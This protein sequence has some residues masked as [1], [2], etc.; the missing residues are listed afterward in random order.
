MKDTVVNSWDD[1]RE[2][3]HHINV[4]N[5]NVFFMDWTTSRGFLTIFQKKKVL[6]SVIK[7]I[8]MERRE[9]KRRVWPPPLRP[10]RKQR[11]KNFKSGALDVNSSIE[12]GFCSGFFENRLS[13]KSMS[14]YLLTCY[15]C[16][17]KNFRTICPLV[18]Y[19]MSVNLWLKWYIIRYWTVVHLKTSITT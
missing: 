6:L 10:I 11:T 2:T 7:I 9:R 18:A 19:K 17:S 14:G 8:L 16:L 4:S 3:W 15:S 12:R 13:Y 1:L 5:V